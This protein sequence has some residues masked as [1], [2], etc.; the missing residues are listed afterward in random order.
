MKI[1]QKHASLIFILSIFFTATLI[2]PQSF[3]K[4][5]EFCSNKKMGSVIIPADE[6][7]ANILHSYDV[8]N[9]TLDLNI[10]NCFITPY[11]KS[12]TASEIITIKA[13]SVINFITLNAVNT[14]L[15]ID[16]VGLAGVSFTHLSNILTIN[17]D[18][19]YTVGEELDI[20]INYH[21]NNV[22]DNAFNVSNGMV[23]TDCEPQGA[24]KWFPCWDRPYDKATVDIT[25]KVPAN[26]KIGSNGRLED[27]VKT[28]DTIWYNWVSRDPVATY[29]VVL[30][31]K[32]NYNL[33]IVYWESI[34]NPGTFIPIRFYYN[35]GEDPSYIKSIIAEMTTYFSQT[36]TEHP[37]EK[38]G[39]ATLNNQFAW[40]GMENQTLTSLCPNCWSES[41]VAHEFAHQWYGDMITCATW[42]DI[43]LNEGFATFSEALWLEHTSGYT[44]YKNDINSNASSYFSGNP[45][46]A[47]YNPAWVIEPPS[48]GE[49]FNYAITYAKSAC[50]L[51]LLRYVLGDE[52]FFNVLS[53]YANDLGLKYRSATTTDFN[54]VV[55][56]VTGENYDWFFN[57]WIY[58]PN[59]PQ[60]QNQYYFSQQSPSQWEVGFLAKQVQTNSGFFKM[61]LNVKIHF[62]TGADST[63]KVMNDVNN[64]W[65]SWV[66]NRQPLSV[67]FDPLNDIV[68]KTA[69]LTQVPPV[70]VEL[71]SF[72]AENKGSFVV[73]NW[74]TASE[75]NNKGFEIERF[76]ISDQK[77]DWEKIG[78]VEGKGTTTVNHFY[79]FTDFIKDYGEYSY[80][81]KQIDFDGSFEL[82]NSINVYAGIQ[83][84]VFSLE[85]NYP[86]P[87]NPETNIKIALLKTSEIKLSVYNSLGELVKIVTQGIFPEGDYIFTFNGNNL[88][89]GIYIYELKA[90]EFRSR[91]KMILQ[92]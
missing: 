66:F 72:N 57:E 78:F 70:P 14:S 12:Y 33:D 69:T 81:L 58:Q 20:S 2:Y 21:H 19:T 47:I 51:H 18:R 35:N 48:T 63:I 1:I 83:P 82:S 10:Y 85:Q 43:W 86:N 60:Y 73:L 17:L 13:D 91:N 65:F 59:H 53:A 41:L 52:N 4:G 5:S 30:S 40:G 87:F 49:L 38:N 36:F 50:V 67:Q 8:I 76:K 80:R 11:P 16:A 54:N 79:S 22:S 29:L 42:A 75:I 15:G 27:S 34:S 74:G 23:F 39:F 62:S 46:W 6:I 9:Y 90:G 89:S 45:G 92:K 28:A 64:Q 3:D 71:T 44:S 55:N 61:P 77:K 25:L 31:G 32:V 26:V 37:F 7:E 56:Y 24:R 84:D 88:P 68:L